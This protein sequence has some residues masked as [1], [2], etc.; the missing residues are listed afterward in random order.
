MYYGSCDL[1]R[2][3]GD[4]TVILVTHQ[5]QFIKFVDNIV[6]MDKGRIIAE[7]AF[8]DLDVIF[9][10]QHIVLNYCY[11]VGN[12]INIQMLFLKETELQIIQLMKEKV[13]EVHEN[14][15]NGMVQTTSHLHST[16]S[17]RRPFSL[18]FD[19]SV[20]VSAI[21]CNAIKALF[22]F[23]KVNFPGSK[24]R[25]RSSNYGS[26][27]RISVSRILSDRRFLSFRLFCVCTVRFSSI[28]CER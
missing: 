14:E 6:I 15:S 2:F 4:K 12:E 17:Q 20:A 11:T 18:L 10:L 27:P 1:F 16:A 22:H 8:E 25:S 3:L 9:S 13:Q 5:I 7:G 24:T 26:C 21:L 23:N 19:T 28:L